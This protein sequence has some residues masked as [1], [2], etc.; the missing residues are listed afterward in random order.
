MRSALLTAL[1]NYPVF[2]VRD[3][4]AVLGKSRPYA[5]LAAFRLKKAGVIHEL[6][7]GKY[8]L[9]QDPFLIASWVVW[10]SYI[11]GWAAL[12]YHKLTEQLPFAIQIST[13]RQ[14]K[15]HTLLFHGTKLDFI[16]IK[17]SAFFGYKRAAYAQNQIFIAEPE[18]AIIDA[19][20]SKRMSLSEAA[21]LV[22]V[23]R[24]KI[25][26]RK[27]LTYSKAARGLVKKLKGV[28]HDKAR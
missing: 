9:E 2:S 10:P 20:A 3:I 16:R 1:K 28:L 6:E 14:R 25:N 13:T 5:S 8:T 4:S 7:K 26:Q 21:E 22:R 19:L 18:K 27:L 23:N 15:N 12:N 24:G 11:S 17:K